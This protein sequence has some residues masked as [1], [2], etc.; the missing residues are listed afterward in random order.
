MKIPKPKA[1]IGDV[2]I[3]LSH[4]VTVKFAALA[5]P[6]T[7]IKKPYWTYRGDW[8]YRGVSYKVSY[9]FDDPDILAN[10]TTGESY[11]LI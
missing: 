8:T 2:V 4:Q 7:V 10:L 11:G 9:D 5:K 3:A 6:T 1:K